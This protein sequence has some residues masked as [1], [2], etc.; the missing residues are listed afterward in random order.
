MVD[1]EVLL[2]SVADRES[3]VDP[4]KYAED[5]FAEALKWLHGTVDL[6]L[7]LGD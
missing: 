2:G 4:I 1:K 7:K 5:E 6:N 3:N